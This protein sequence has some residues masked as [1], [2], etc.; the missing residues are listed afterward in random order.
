L[1]VIVKA[2]RKLIIYSVFLVVAGCSTK[3][4]QSD[5][6]YVFDYE[7]ILTDQEEK[8]LDSIYK[9]HDAK[10]TNQIAL[11]TTPDYDGESNMLGFAVKFGNVHGVGV[12]G[13]DNGVVIVFSNTLHETRINN[14]YGTEKVL[15]DE[16]AKSFIDSIMIPEFKKGNMFDGLFAGSQAVIEF[17]ERPGNEIK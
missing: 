12:K 17:L 4:Q 7:N 3:A 8:S 1:A 9:L 6:S 11:V 2:M 14:G 10:T 13:K 15:K 16:I 5:R